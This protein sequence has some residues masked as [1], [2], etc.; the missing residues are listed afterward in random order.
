[1]KEAGYS[2]GV[3]DL[4]IFEPRGMYQGL[5]IEVKTDKGRPSPE[6]KEWCKNLNDRGWRA[7]ITKGLDDALDVI[8]E[9]FDLYE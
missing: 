5:A 4:L 2:K 6:Q 8:S 9:Y 3:P 1:M 7:E